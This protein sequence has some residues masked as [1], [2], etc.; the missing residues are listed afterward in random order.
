MW[1]LDG[2]QHYGRLLECA[3]H[4]AKAQ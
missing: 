2:F 3:W 4:P 1:V